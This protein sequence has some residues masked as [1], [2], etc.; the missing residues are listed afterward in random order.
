MYI[1]FIILNVDIIPEKLRK[2]LEG[3]SGVLEKK[4]FFSLEGFPY[5]KMGMI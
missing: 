2:T 1:A 4:R 5:K 3:V